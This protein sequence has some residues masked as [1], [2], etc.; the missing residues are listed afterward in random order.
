M[1]AALL[2][3]AA[4]A[5]ASAIGPSPLAAQEHQPAWE[6]VAIDDDGEGWIDT[7]WRD[8]AQLDGRPVELV[9]IRM[10]LTDSDGAPMVFD[11]IM[12]VD[13]P[14]QTIGMKET[15]L[16]QSFYGDQI[17]A[18][19]TTVTMDFA[20]SP[21]SMGDLAILAHACTGATAAQ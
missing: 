2:A 3:L 16:F 9:L 6:A 4:A 8:S 7:A 14:A 12:A 11:A 5:P 10:N 15:W 19:I 17:R 13:C 21:P 1:I 20:D 18:P